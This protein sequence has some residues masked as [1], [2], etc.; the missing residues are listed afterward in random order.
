MPPIVRHLVENQQAAT[1]IEY[2]LIVA[3][4]AIAAVSPVSTIG[5]T[6]QN[7]LGAASTAMN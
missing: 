6:V 5:Q 4:I 1:L 7:I 2:S 3:L